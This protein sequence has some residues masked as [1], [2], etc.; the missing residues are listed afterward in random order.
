MADAAPTFPLAPLSRRA[1]ARAIDAAAIALL[2]CVLVSV[3]WWLG[4][5]T[6]PMLA[7][8]VAILGWS[9]APLVAFGATP[10]M[11]L[12][13]LEMVGPDGRRPDP[14]ETAFRELLGRALLPGSYLVVV[15]VGLVGTLLGR[16]ELR[17]P[18]SLGLLLVFA[19]AV[20][21]LVGGAGHLL[22]LAREDRRSL[23]DLVGR[24]RVVPRA[25]ATV[26]FDDDE[27]REQASAHRRARNVLAGFDA[28]LL[29]IA[30]VIPFV[31]GRPVPAHQ[32]QIYADR[33]MR[34]RA[35]MLFDTNP[36][37]PDL[38]RDL[39]DRLERTGDFEGAERV[40]AKHRQAFV[41]VE[42][43]RELK[44]RESLAKNPR[45]E[46]SADALLELL[47]DQGRNDDARSVMHAF[48]EAEP[49]PRER[50]RLG[51]W[52]QQHGFAAE[53]ARELAQALTDGETAAEAH[54]YLGL[55]LRDL[56]RTAEARAEL[57]AA[58]ADV[59]TW[60]EVREAIQAL[61]APDASL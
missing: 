19:S 30:L 11:R 48:F 56:G 60:D 58:L 59:P 47:S 45:D 52:L 31:L 36:G 37:D 54:A 14:I 12:L 17:A 25:L 38:A 43:A 35:Q 28:G 27:N 15:A 22:A 8:L 21:S 53:A 34:E 10:G 26:T 6:L 29:V 5:F 9:V 50:V 40:R 39:V 32:S 7:A 13:G 1:A 23:A 55:A 49:N 44:L 46:E 61:P 24:T 2:T 41:A 51:A 3:P 57:G 18:G 42:R 33:L 4:G 16:G 20:L